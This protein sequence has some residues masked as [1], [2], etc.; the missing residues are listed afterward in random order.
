M[1]KPIYRYVLST[2]VM[3]LLLLTSCATTELT[4]LWRDETYRDHPRKILVIGML[5]TP[6]NQRILEDEL[7]RQLKARGTDAVASYTVL[8]EQVQAN[9]E[10]ITAKMNELGADA[11][12]ISRLMDKK[13]VTT[14]VHSNPPP[15]GYG[16][17]WQGYYSYSPGYTVQDEYA[18]VQTNL[19][20]VKTDK[21]IWTAATET[22]ISGDYADTL[23]REFAEVIGDTLARQKVIA[24]GPAK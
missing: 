16:Y 17:G 21:L 13:S 1:T 4:S 6:A 9:K 22:W 14:Y 19:Y 12:L 11:V 23:I 5:K 15:A 18:V 7:V 3:A 10:T 2:F 24:A 20:D 8:P